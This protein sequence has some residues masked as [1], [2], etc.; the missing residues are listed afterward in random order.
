MVA[1]SITPYRR[2]AALPNLIVINLNR[3]FNYYVVV[4]LVME[5]EIGVYLYVYAFMYL[6]ILGQYTL[7]KNK[8][9]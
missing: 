4:R 8:I 5:I 2:A 7:F 6:R 3:G 9:Q 1:D